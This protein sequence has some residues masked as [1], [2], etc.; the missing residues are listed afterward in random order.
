MSSLSFCSAFLLILAL[1]GK[2]A[3]A[4]G[5][6]ES[7]IAGD[8]L[9]HFSLD[10]PHTE[11][12]ALAFAETGDNGTSTQ[13]EI[14]EHKSSL[15][16]NPDGLSVLVVLKREVSVSYVKQAC[17]ASL[18]I[19]TGH[20]VTE[21]QAVNAT[22]R[23]GCRRVYSELFVGFYGVFDAHGWAVMEK[24]FHEDIVEIEPEFEVTKEG[25]LLDVPPQP[26]SSILGSRHKTGGRRLLEEAQPDGNNTQDVSG[27]LWGLDRMD[28]TSWPLDNE[29]RSTLDG[30]DGKGATIFVLDSG[31]RSMHKEFIVGS[32][33]SRVGSGYDFV[34]EDYEPEDCDGH[35]THVAALAAGKVVGVAKQAEVVPV[36]V[37]GCNGQGSI[38]TLLAGLEYVAKRVQDMDSSRAV[39]VMSLSVQAGFWSRALEDSVTALEEEYGMSVVVAAGNHKADACAYSPGLVS[40]AL[41]VGASSAYNLMSSSS[42]QER[43]PD[44]PD[45]MWPYSNYGKCVDLF[46]PGA[47]IV[48][49][50][51][52]LFKCGTANHLYS[53][54]SGTSMA[55]AYAAGVVA[56]MTPFADPATLVQAMKER[57][58][59][60]V[61]TSYAFKPTTNLLIQAESTAPIVLD[62]QRAGPLS[63]PTPAPLAAPVLLAGTHLV[64]S[65]GGLD[66]NWELDYVSSSKISMDTNFQSSLEQN[67]VAWYI[68]LGGGTRID[69]QRA[70]PFRTLTSG[71]VTFWARGP[72]THA[73]PAVIELTLANRDGERSTTVTVEVGP[74]AH[75]A[76]L[77]L[78]Q[79]A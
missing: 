39:A 30:T 55:A 61:D 68:S 33:N 79:S 13:D 28:Q 41:T 64:Y 74:P 5:L 35:G 42:Q 10:E 69:I 72:V 6:A 34:E 32:G 15:V 36:R 49:A 60:A 37:L 59:A 75:G 66:S 51:G 58:V 31:V 43:T 20:L 47:N 45:F 25:I 17:Q 57:S 11:V 67:G 1:A 24:F 53:W 76:P 18:V 29:F 40:S 19:A 63:T 50:C 56:T 26:L 77:M 44:G 46:A 12:E 22:N 54:Q 23:V 16:L 9:I 3:L 65:T 27:M 73:S 52:D 48:S 14:L 21:A 62:I 70:I 4:L 8:E 2:H 7:D 38:A 78:A 71:K